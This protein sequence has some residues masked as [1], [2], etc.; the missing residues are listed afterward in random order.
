MRAVSL[1][2]ALPAGPG[3]LSAQP[4]YIGINGALGLPVINGTC[5]TCHVSP[6]VGNHSFSVPLNIGMTAYPALPALDIPGMPVPHHSMQQWDFAP[7][8][9]SWPGDD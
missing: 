2:R 1:L 6:N 8:N 3:N 4:S 7:D 9:G 5:T